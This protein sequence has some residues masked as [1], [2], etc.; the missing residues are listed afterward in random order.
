MRA[1]GRQA[2]YAKAATTPPWR[3]STGQGFP[4][5]P[6]NSQFRGETALFPAFLRMRRADPTE[7]LLLRPL[8]A[9]LSASKALPGVQ[10]P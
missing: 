3:I 1:R 2:G 10:V 8:T 5:V 4:C 6:G 7:K 9:L